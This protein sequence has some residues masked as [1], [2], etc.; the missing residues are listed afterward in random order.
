[1]TDEFDR[2]QAQNSMD[3]WW[4]I[5]RQADV[6]VPHTVR[7]EITDTETFQDGLELPLPN[8]TALQ[9][10]VREVSGPPAF[11]RS[12]LMSTKHDMGKGSRVDNVESAR[13]NIAGIVENHHLAWGAPMPSSYYV[14][15]WLDLYSTY[16]AWAYDYH[17]Y[18]TPIA[19]EQR[20]FINDGKVYDTGFYWPMDGITRPDRD[21]WQDRYYDL[22]ETVNK[23]SDRL[24]PLIE[25]VASEFTTGY[26]SADFALT[27]SLEW[28]CIDM[29]RGEF[30][31]H[32][33]DIEPVRTREDIIEGGINV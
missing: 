28:Y 2:V 33:E 27:E 9:D 20:A 25:K 14:R 31:W 16:S 15:E 26:W 6:P 3:H 32:P 17:D 8:E 5:L 21:D 29:A 22:I 7:L 23:N 10:A 1:M 13:S 4:P 18:P 11:L 30:S 12:D 24:R 19:A